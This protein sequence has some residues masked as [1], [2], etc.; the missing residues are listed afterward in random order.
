MSK[1][2]L[3]RITVRVKPNAKVTAVDKGPD[4]QYV[5]RVKERPV[6]GR[7]NDAVIRALSVHFKIPRSRFGIVR[8][9]AGKTKVIAVFFS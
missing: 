4:G 6:D 8:G 7:A 3:T 9:R 5:V 1:K 2:G